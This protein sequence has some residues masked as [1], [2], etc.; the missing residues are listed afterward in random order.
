MARQPHRPR[1]DIRQYDDLAGEWWRPGGAFSLLHGI[2]AARGRLVPPATRPDAVLVDVGCGGGLLAP[3]VA[4]KG[5]RH[6]GVDLVTS[7]LEQAAAHGIAVVRGDALRL[8]LAD[9]FADV[10]SAG[11]LLEHVPDLSG[12]VAEV[13]R[14]LRPG[15]LLVLD[16]LNDTALCRLVA[17]TLAER[18][19]GG[20]PPGIHDPA[21][22]VDPAVLTRECARHGVRITVR[23]LRPAVVATMRWLAT[24]K[25]EIPI[26]PTWSKAVLYQGLGR[27]NGEVT[28]AAG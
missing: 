15:G 10:V 6:V 11:E 18:L 3:H 12:A 26:V 24:R 9:G 25:G 8:P 14:I 22:F 1:N 21:L 19:P 7:A 27:K 5:Y 16:T 4:G 2:A 17:V 23:G 28:G 20:A 13:C